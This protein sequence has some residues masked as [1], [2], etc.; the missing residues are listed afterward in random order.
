MSSLLQRIGRGA[1]LALLLLSIFAAPAANVRAQEPGQDPLQQLVDSLPTRVKVGQLVIVSFPGM[2]VS[3]GSEIATLVS[4]YAIGGVWLRPENTNFGAWN[5]DDGAITRVAPSELI[6]MTNQLQRLAWRPSRTITTPL[7]DL[8]FYQGSSFPLFVAVEPELQGLS[9]TRFISGTSFL[10]SPMSIGATWNRALAEAAG[11]VAGRELTAMGFNLFFGPNLDVLDTPRPGDPADLGTSVFGGDGYW[12]GELGRAYVRGV[13]Q[14][15][16]GRMGLL[17]RHFPGLGNADRPLSEE[18]PTIQRSL[19]QLKR[20]E[21][22]PFLAAASQAPGAASVADGLLVTHARYQGFQG[23]IRESTRPL[24]LDAQGLQVALTD[25]SAWRKSGGLL[26]ADNLGLPAMRRFY[27]PRELTFNARQV[28]RDALFAGNDLLI[29]DRFAA[30]EDWTEHFSNVRT[31]L[32]FLAQLYESDPAVKARVDEAVSR[33]LQL[34]LRLNP[35]MTLASTLRDAEALSDVLGAGATVNS[36][37]AVNAI[38]RLAPLTDDLLPPEPQDGA[39]MVIFV[40]ERRVTLTPEGAS[41]AQLPVAQLPREL[42]MQTLM[43]LY[44]PDGTGQVTPESVAVYSFEDLLQFLSAPNLTAEEP[45]SELLLNLQRAQWV[46]FATTGLS[47]VEPESSALKLFLEQQAALLESRLVVLNFGPPYDL[48]ST[49]VSKIDLYYTLYSSGEM[50]VQTA[51]Q[52]LFRDLPVTGA[53]PVSI[54][55]L[56]YALA[57]LV[58]PDPDQ[59]I[60]LNVVDSQGQEMAIEEIRDIRKDDVIYLRTSVI[61]DGNRNPVPDKTPVLFTLVYPQEDRTSTIAAETKDGVAFASVTLDRVGQL[62][63]TVESKPAPPLFHLQLTIREESVIMI[64]ITPTPEP[65]DGQPTPTQE[66]VI[67]VN[68]YLPEPLRV[69]VPQRG[70]LLA[71][72]ITGGL[73]CAATGFWWGRERV[74]SL[75]MGLRLGLWGF[76]GG[77]GAYLLF[78]VMHRGPLRE[79]FFTLAGREFIA[80]IVA[81]CGG[82]AL[83]LLLRGL[84]RLRL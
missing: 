60:A 78:A 75:L 79:Q 43:R 31:T 47:R 50:F 72:G 19:E 13:H 22:A 14:G 53:S 77:L 45:A 34:K 84:A 11:Q 82:I 76:V 57:D 36:Q 48:D 25:F 63:I 27:D 38:S 23:T 42:V 8:P 59:V 5:P 39:N 17:P 26:V 18:L 44:G 54:P 73:M 68:K 46:I 6:S 64:S 20:V 28:A 37:I 80:G 24:S 83:L 32:D 66:P 3:E 49:D 41:V 33:I 9:I 74:G 21:L 55:A 67:V 56:N 62:D 15:S 4:T 65:L 40:Q 16:Q 52:A 71:W 51:F 2:D 7:S 29:L 70:F 1:L 10:P 12:V 58:L 61:Y 30:T 81:L 69:P 35:D